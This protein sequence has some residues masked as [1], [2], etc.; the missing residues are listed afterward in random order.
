MDSFSPRPI[1]NALCAPRFV[2]DRRMLPNTDQ[3]PDYTRA[4][5]PDAA[6]DERAVMPARARSP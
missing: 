1:L 6:D 2:E 3:W 5:H 4:Q